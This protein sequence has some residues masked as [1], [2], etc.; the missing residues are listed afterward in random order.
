MLI[1]HFKENILGAK[2]Q[3]PNLK[4]SF[5]IVSMTWKNNEHKYEIYSFKVGQ[6]LY[7]IKKY[8]KLISNT[9]LLP[10]EIE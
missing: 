9:E 10:E 6:S 1:S 5:S 3:I 2:I 8:S 7:D 4:K